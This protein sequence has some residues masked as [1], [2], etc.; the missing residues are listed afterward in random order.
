MT[1][2]ND[3]ENI[4]SLE[5][6]ESSAKGYVVNNW[7]TVAVLVLISSSIV[8]IGLL[9]GFPPWFFG[10]ALFA[11]AIF[12]MQRNYRGK[13]FKAFATSNDFKYQESGTVPQQSGLIFSI[14]QDPQFSDI[15]KGTYR[16]WPLR[17]FEYDSDISATGNKRRDFTRNVL[18]VDFNCK[19]PSFYLRAKPFVIWMHMQDAMD[20]TGYTEKIGLEGNFDDYFHLWIHP[21][22]HI[23]VLTV[24]A[25]DIMEL[26]LSLKGHD[27]ELTKDGMLY[28][29][30]RLS[31]K[32][33]LINAFNIIEALS[34]KVGRYA[35]REKNLTH[36]RMRHEKED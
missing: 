12:S 23:K 26:I 29:Y 27:I 15:V 7:R 22:T 20:A 3:R 13:L 33:D 1:T 5:N 25:P 19:V 31:N 30:G 6:V 36:S 28:I 2:A 18:T 32:Q 21:N 9:T 10:I 14:G 16:Q 8:I 11:G 4:P 24:L 34:A 17:L 35:I